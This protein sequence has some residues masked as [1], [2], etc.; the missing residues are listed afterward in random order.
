MPDTKIVWEIILN[1]NSNE[2]NSLKNTSGKS[3]IRDFVDRNIARIKKGPLACPICREV[4][5]G[6]AEL[7]RH[8]KIHCT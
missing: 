3:R 7:G 2:I 6:I 8:L 1:K 4:F 5:P